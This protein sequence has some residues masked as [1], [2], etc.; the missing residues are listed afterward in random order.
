MWKLK[1]VKIKKENA[2]W[3]SCDKN[4]KTKDNPIKVLRNCCSEKINR[5][6]IVCYAVRHSYKHNLITLN[7]IHFLQIVKIWLIIKIFFSF[8]KKVAQY[9]CCTHFYIWAQMLHFVFFCF[10]L[11]FVMHGFLRTLPYIKKSR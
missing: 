6:N 7:T 1:D 4:V 8:W 10:F 11:H 9:S 3:R 5:L 2:A